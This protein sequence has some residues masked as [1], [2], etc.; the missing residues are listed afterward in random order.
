MSQ[1]IP[2]INILPDI[3]TSSPFEL[4]TR[5]AQQ[6]DFVKIGLGPQTVYL[7]SNPDYFQAVLR[8]DA[9]SF[10]KSPKLYEAARMM[11]G[12]GLV[13][14]SGDFWFRQRR[15]IQPYFHKKQVADFTSNIVNAI[16]DTLESWEA[17]DKRHS[18]LKSNMSQLTIEVIAQTLF[19]KNVVSP[20]EIRLVSEHLI[21]LADYIALRGYLP[22]VPLG[23][24]LPGHGRY[25]RS[26]QDLYR[27]VE[28][29]IELGKTDQMQSGTLLS[30][31]VHAVDEDTNE[32]MTVSQLFDETMTIFSAGFETTSV[33]LAWLIYLLDQYPD[34]KEKVQNEIDTV[35]GDKEPTFEDFQKL[36]YTQMAFQESLRILPASPMV[37]RTTA[38]NV[39]LGSHHIPE[40]KM[41]LMFIY[42]LHHNPDV[43]ENPEQFDPMRFA[44]EAARNRSQFAF[45][46]FIVGS[47]QCLG[48]H[49]AMLE[50]VL[51][52][53]MI[54]QKF[55]VIIPPNQNIKPK[56]SATLTPSPSIE[57]VLRHR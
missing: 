2:K 37:P 30:M 27:I 50:G 57:F 35:L 1:T 20:E 49:F 31:M 42:G 40:G 21:F 8:D 12:N 48:R 28:R 17:G 19:G 15:M 56:L 3:L 33:T 36:T 53:A 29:F 9:S 11:L 52:I 16:G 5:A 10:V 46:P 32:R 44:P 18:N 41:L 6:G 23:M 25:K 13:T 22:F 43:W 7:V 38:K 14:S 39:Q 4:L 47:R 24:P 26:M 55:E 45:M 51:A 54:M 34:I